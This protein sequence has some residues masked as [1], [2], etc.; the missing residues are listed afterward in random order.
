MATLLEI[1][2]ANRERLKNRD[3]DKNFLVSASAGTGKTYITVERAFNML[4]D[5]KL[6][7]K[8]QNVVMITFTRKAATEMK[9]RLNKRIREAMESAKENDNKK[10]AFLE[11]LLNS[12]PEMQISTIHS[13]CQ[14]VLNAFP[15]ESGIGF[16]PEF[17]S[18]EG[19]PDGRSEVFFNELWN[20]GKCP[21]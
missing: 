1:D 8:P 5:E 17:D 6:G 15:L 21:D 9:I 2:E 7:I 18:E 10:F 20:T 3:F 4:C 19:G 12:L 11:S 13:F 16:A 14:R